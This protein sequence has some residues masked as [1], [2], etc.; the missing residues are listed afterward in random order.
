[1]IRAIVADDHAMVRRSITM[2]LEKADDIE[3][4]GEAADGEEAVEL[5]RKLRPDIVVMDISMPRMDGLQATEEIQTLRQPAN[6]LIVSM[7]S[8]AS[9]VR[10]AMDKG[11]RGYLSKANLFSLLLDAIRT[12]QSGD[13]FMCPQLAHLWPQQKKN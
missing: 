1:M 11:A 9:L 4:V 8:D 12:V 3:I 5:V 7:Y 2:L 10:R 13:I 6:V